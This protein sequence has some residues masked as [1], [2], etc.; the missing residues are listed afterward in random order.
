KINEHS[1]ENLR[2]HEHLA[3]AQ[4]A[5]QE[6][7]QLR[8]ALGWQQ[9]VP[10]SLKPSRVV[11]QDPANWWRTIMIDVGLRDKIRPNMTVLTSEGL[12]GRVTD[13]G[14]DL[15]RVVLVGHP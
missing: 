6:N 9:R 4:E 3:Q 1:K 7:A 11:G 10:W 13:V 14:F 15:S 5:S 12:V 8:R 2:L